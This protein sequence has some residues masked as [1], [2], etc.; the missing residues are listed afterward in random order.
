MEVNILEKA[1]EV[2][3]DKVFS[4]IKDLAGYQIDKRNYENLCREAYNKLSFLDQVK[5]I[6]DFGDSISLYDFF[7]HPYLIDLTKNKKEFTVNSIKDFACN[8]KV[9]ISGIVGQGKSIL[10]R[11]LAIQESFNGERFPVFVELKELEDNESLEAFMRKSIESWLQTDNQKIVSYLLKEGKVI[12]FFDGFDEI[13]TS[14]MEKIVRDFEKI[15][16]KFPKLNFIVS[17]RPEDS[18]DKST[19]FKKYLIKK[20]ELGDQLNIIQKLVKDNQLQKNLTTTLSK[21]S[22]DIIG[23]LVTPLMV[24]FYVYL[25]KT[26]QIIGDNLKLFY[27]KIFDLVA[28][29]HDGTKIL[30]KRVYAT[31]LTIDQLEAAFECICYLCSRQGTFFFNEYSFREIVEK[32]IKFNKFQCAIDD[33]IKDLTTGLCFIGKESESF[34]FMHTSIAEFFAAKFVSKNAD[35][36][37]LYTDLKNNYSK[38]DNLIKYLEVI[39]KKTFYINFLDGLL[40]ENYDYFK[41]KS[42]VDNILISIKDYNKVYSKEDMQR[43]RKNNI[44]VLILFEKSVHP[45]FVFK[46]LDS[47]EGQVQK[48][49]SKKYKYANSFEFEIIYSGKRVDE[50]VNSEEQIVTVEEENII[51]SRIQ[52]E[53]YYLYETVDVETQHGTK[54]KKDIDNKIKNGNFESINARSSLDLSNINL[55]NN[56]FILKLDAMKKEIAEYKLPRAINDLF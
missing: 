8:K 46:F 39:D 3:V 51:S 26:E 10:M 35:I 27:N 14:N 7:V 53:N 6:N 48:D 54:S 49:L 5:T 28:R 20:L 13:K 4:N 33:L 41:S 36:K 9:L 56:S 12:F 11:H 25:Y 37:G 34:A 40:N 45:Y 29:K 17:S 32:T 47:F 15:D 52:S 24:N 30:Y 31:K 19:I 42:I 44:S 55:H 1:F 23:V 2:L 21:S 18:I 38:Y 50:K 22:K 16:K 43:L